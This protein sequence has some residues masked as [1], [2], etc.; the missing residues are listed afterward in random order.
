MVQA[1]KHKTLMEHYDQALQSKSLSAQDRQTLTAQ[2]ANIEHDLKH[3]RSELSAMEAN[4]AFGRVPAENGGAIDVKL[5]NTELLD[6]DGNLPRSAR[7]TA[8]WDSLQTGAKSAHSGVNKPAVVDRDGLTLPNGTKV[9][10]I[11]GLN[12]YRFTKP[13][14]EGG[15]GGRV[16]YDE[17]SG[18]IILAINMRSRVNPN[19]VDRVEVPFR[20]TKDGWRPDFSQYSPYATKIDS[21]LEAK[22]RVHF[23]EANKK[24]AADWAKD[25]S[26]KERLGLSPEMVALVERGAQKSPAPYT[27]DHVNHEGDIRLVD[28]DIHGLFL[29]NGG[30]KDWGNK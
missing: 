17:K 24:L 2:R 1:A 22:R 6:L 23:G 25:P 11:D 27:W 5:K 21:T 8:S 20:P 26:I 19:L 4:P 30:M 3:W 18:T 14:S 28:A 16:F 7:A 10:N 13:Q 9:A 29:H 15:Y 12:L